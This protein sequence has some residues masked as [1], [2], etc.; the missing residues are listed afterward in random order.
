MLLQPARLPSARPSPSAFLQRR[1][2]SCSPPSACLLSRPPSSLLCCPASCLSP[3]LTPHSLMARTRLI[4]RLTWGE[5]VLLL[6]LSPD[7]TSLSSLRYPLISPSPRSQLLGLLWH[8]SLQLGVLSYG[9]G[10][11][12]WLRVWACGHDR[13][14]GQGLGEQRVDRQFD[15]LLLGWTLTTAAIISLHAPVKNMFMVSV[16]GSSSHFTVMNEWNTRYLVLME[17][18]KNNRSHFFF[19]T[20]EMSIWNKNIELMLTLSVHTYVLLTVN[21][22]NK[23]NIK[24]RCIVVV[25][26][27]KK[28]CLILS[29]TNLWFSIPSQ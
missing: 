26:N 19:F 20:Q 18:C 27:K 17:T 16:V 22:G 1:V 25:S 12:S 21:W 24:C 13:W 3:P 28:N 8:W 9:L 6:L 7:Q 15:K 14:G 4:D 11:E 5:V 23:I 29:E 10:N 2:S